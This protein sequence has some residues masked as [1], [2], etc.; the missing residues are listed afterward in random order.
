M[1]SSF[2]TLS[3]VF[4]SLVSF[5]AVS[6]IACS[7]E[8]SSGAPDG[9][10][11]QDGGGSADAGDCTTTGTGSLAVTIDGLP[12]GVSAAVTVA[13]SGGSPESVVATRTLSLPAGL[14]TASAERVAA[15]DPI[16]RPA[17]EPS[18]EGTAGRPDAGTGSTLCLRG[19]QTTNVTVRYSRIPSSSKIWTGNATG[20]TASF[21]GYAPSAVAATGAPAATVAAETHGSGGYAFDQAGNVWII[22]GTVGDPPVARYPASVLGASGDKTPDITIT[23]PAF[24]GGY[25]GPSVVAFDKSGNL[26]VSIVFAQK[27]VKFS[28]A[29]IAQ[30]G[31]PTPEVELTNIDP[32]ALAFDASGNLWAAGAGKLHRY[33]ASR[34]VANAAASDLQLDAESPPPVIGSLGSPIG[35]A[36]DAAGNLWSNYGGVLARLTPADLGGTGPKTVTP[37]VQIALS[38]TGLPAGIAFDEGGGLWLA[39]SAGK[40]VRVGPSLLTASGTVTPEIVITSPDVGYA[41][42][43]GLYPAPAALPLYH[44]LP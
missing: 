19:G 5:A 18:I 37:T 17:Y 23:S 13:R 34:I 40:F 12:T 10:V 42:S 27:V 36:F 28:A 21:L 14:Y 44:R 3:L 32:G 16:A 11:P 33:D 41:Q 8:P 9:G 2:A 15:P 7:S 38:V 20:G 39:G 25:P 22:G 30:G 35:L 1:R 43:F 26:W 31:T 24:E 4:V 29:Q 6:G